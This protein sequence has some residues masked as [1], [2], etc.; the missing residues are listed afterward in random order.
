MGQFLQRLGG[1]ED[2]ADLPCS[3]IGERKV[4]S[5]NLY[6]FK[7]NEMYFSIFYLSL[8]NTS[9]VLRILRLVYVEIM[10]LNTRMPPQYHHLT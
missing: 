7:V 1:G 10:I 5:R 8:L 3:P 4:L 2:W 6:I 9:S